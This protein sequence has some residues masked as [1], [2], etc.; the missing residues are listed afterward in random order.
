MTGYRGRTG[1]Y[2]MLTLSPE[3]KKLVNQDAELSKIK[4]LARREGMKSLRLNG[5]E[6][7]VAGLTTAEEITKITPPVD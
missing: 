1:I 4:E 6:K 2:E 3:I 5:T 7:V